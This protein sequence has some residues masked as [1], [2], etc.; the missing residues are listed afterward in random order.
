MLI[1]GFIWLLAFQL[2][3]EIIARQFGWLVPGP[4]I[5]LVLL[6]IYLLFVSIPAPLVQVSD[7]LIKNLGVMFLPPAAGLFFLPDEVLGQWPALLAAVVG[8]TALSLFI[9]ALLLK[10]LCRRL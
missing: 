3:G 9:A 7:T 4:V 1:K 6:F 8:G 10:F 2:V 5:G